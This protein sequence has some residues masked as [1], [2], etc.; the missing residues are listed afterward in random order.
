[1]LN[2]RLRFR[3]REATTDINMPITDG[4]VKVEGFELEMVT[5]G[6]TDACITGETFDGTIIKGC[7]A[8]RTL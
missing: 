2:P 6:D 3:C 4:T 1:M 8:V 5:Q 7:D